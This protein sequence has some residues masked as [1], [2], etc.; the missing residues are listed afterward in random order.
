MHREEV[1]GDVAGAA[2]D[3][4][5]DVAADDGGERECDA[6][7]SLPSEATGKGSEGEGLGAEVLAVGAMDDEGE[8]AEGVG[9]VAAVDADFD[10]MAAGDEGAGDVGSPGGF[11]P[12]DAAD[13]AGEEKDGEGTGHGGG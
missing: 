6:V 5:P 2:V 8:I 13:E 4:E 9:V 11:G 7:G 3:G 12:G 1:A 10:A